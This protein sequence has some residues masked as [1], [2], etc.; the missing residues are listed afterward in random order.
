MKPHAKVRKLRNSNRH[1]PQ[2]LNQWIRQD[3]TALAESTD[4]FKFAYLGEQA[5]SKYVGPET[6]PAE[7]RRQRAINKWLATERNNSATNERLL[8]TDP[9]Y[10]ILPKVTYQRFISK[11][12]E[13]VEGVIGAMPSEEALIGLF[14]GGAS[15]SKTRLRSSPALKYL[16]KADVTAP[17]LDLFRE[18]VLPECPM[19]AQLIEDTWKQ[20]RIVEGNILFT[21][22]K[23]TE[24]DRCAAKE[25]DL[26]MFMQ[27]GLG[28]E[29]RKGLRR[30]GINLNDQGINANLAREGS[31]TGQLMTLDLSSASDSVCYELVAQCL[32][33]CWFTMLNA[34]RSPITVIDGESHVNEMFSSMG[35]GFTFELESLLFFA[36]TRAVVYFRGVRGRVSVY[37]DDIIA[38]ASVFA[39]LT[40]ALSYLGF[41]VNTKKSF[42]D[43][44][45][46][47][48]CGAHWYA[49]TDVTPFYIRRPITN[50]IELTHFLNQLRKWAQVGSV[51]DPRITDIWEFYSSYVPPSMW[52]GQDMDDPHALVTG[53]PPRNR[54]VPVRVERDRNHMG[55]YLYWLHLGGRRQVVQD[56]IVT[57]SDGSAGHIFR[58]RPNLQAVSRNVPSLLSSSGDIFQAPGPI[59]AN[60]T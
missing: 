23:S 55:G 34:L 28:D 32:P 2:D 11:V 24:I 54:M 47:E 26:N 29:I 38:P 27:K 42:A 30:W 57:S 37:G 41:E 59:P 3:L 15:T 17:A 12:C 58:L 5:F 36:I 56:P 44:P 35:N 25:P 18:F 19:W 51:C 49:G 13:I 43:G 21:V 9:E 46:R 39:E 48:S 53:D 6:E 22:P 33:P 20:P 60:P 45:F 16:E 52:G 50:L 8:I 10:N 40:W 14:S 7:V 1:V 31:V 4:E